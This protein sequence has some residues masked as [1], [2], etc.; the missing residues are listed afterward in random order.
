MNESAGDKLFDTRPS[1]AAPRG[2]AKANKAVE[3]PA[4]PRNIV[5]YALVALE[6]SIDRGEGGLTYAVPEPLADL[7]VGDRV[8][9]PLGRGN[10]PAAGY[11]VGRRDEADASIKHV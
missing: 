6:R 10:K 3:P 9:V 5:G 11:V 8:S 1:R 7:A 4:T 2:S